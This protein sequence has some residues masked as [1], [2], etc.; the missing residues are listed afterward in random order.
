MSPGL[1]SLWSEW[2]RRLAVVAGAAVALFALAQ[3][4]PVW[5]ACGRGAAALVAVALHG[6]W[7]GRLIAWSLAGDRQEAAARA[8]TV[9][10]MGRNA[11]GAKPAGDR[12]G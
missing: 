10:E 2:E 5:V 3:H 11:A 4:C 6:R 9:A 12:R 7:I 1:A 8:A